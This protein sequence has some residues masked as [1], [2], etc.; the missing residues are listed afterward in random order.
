MKKIVLYTTYSLVFNL[1]L[2]IFLFIS[3]QN[4]NNKKRVNL[5]FIESIDLPISF[6]VGSSFIMGSLFGN[7]IYS[8]IDNKKNKQKNYFSER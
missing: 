5:I 8:L 6:I 3:I 2:L 4:S 1:T 7:V